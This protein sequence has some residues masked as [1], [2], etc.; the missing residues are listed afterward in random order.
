MSCEELLAAMNQYVDGTIDPGICEEFASHLAGCNPC[1]IVV[2]NIRHTIHLFK[3]GEQYDLPEPLR[4]S[5]DDQ[6]RAKWKAKF[7]Q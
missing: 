1:Q 7:G 6:L 3:A 2:D 5:L 4:R